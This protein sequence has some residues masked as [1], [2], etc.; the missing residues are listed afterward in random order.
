MIKININISLIKEKA[1]FYAKEIWNLEFNLPIEINGRYKNVMGSVQYKRNT[2]KEI[3]EK[4][5]LARCLF[6]DDYNELTIEDVLL[7]ELCHWYCSITGKQ[8]RDG[9]RDFENELCRIGVSSSGSTSGA[10]L[11]YVGKCEKCGQEIL[12]RK[13]KNILIKYFKNNNYLTICCH[14]QIIDGGT[15]IIKDTYKVSDKVKN[16]NKKFKEYLLKKSA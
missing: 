3:P 1:K 16:L 11:Y 6:E 4:L 7:H 5:I 2:K 14:S 13:N 15:I 8:S 12:K 9:S 10:G